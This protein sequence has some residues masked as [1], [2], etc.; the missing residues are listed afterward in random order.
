MLNIPIEELTKIKARIEKCCETKINAFSPTIS[1]APKDIEN[2]EI[3]SIRK[4]IEFYLKK[5]ITDLVFQ[6]K[7][8][9]SYSDIY[10]KKNIEESYV[11]SRNAFIVKKIPHELIVEKLRDLHQRFD[12]EQEQLSMVLIQAEIMPWR[13][14]GNT[15][16]ENEFN[17]YLDA[18]QTHFDYLKNADL[19]RKIEQVKTSEAF[20]KYKAD[21]KAL[22]E[23]EFKK[24]YASHVIRQYSAIESFL[25]K[26]LESYETGLKTYR[27]QIDYFGKESELTFKAFNILKKIYNDGTEIIPN[28]NTTFSQINDDEMLHLDFSNTELIE[29][30]IN[31]VYQ[32]YN[33]LTGEMEEGIMIKPKLCFIK[34]MPPALKVRNNQY[35]TMIYGVDF[36]ENY[37]N[38]LRKRKIDSKLKCSIYD[39]MI[40]WE[41]LLVP[42][43][44]INSENYH[45]KNLLLDRIM[46]E[47]AENQLDSRL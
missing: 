10:L 22:P 1:P 36:L 23:K 32:W 35:L 44:E 5:G 24:V 13:A 3:E 8:M 38:N 29:N 43:N 6:K 14:L 46:G 28:D 20:L 2:N 19:Y 40:N 26:D 34:D 31:S 25:I 27:T 15:L 30:Q 37:P 33:S 11:A 17:G 39:W 47:R 18:H 45:F 12:W 16:V 41:L 42:Y 9:G 4:G 7:Y 21:Q